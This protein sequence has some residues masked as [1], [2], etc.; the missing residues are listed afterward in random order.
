MMC[1][2]NINL[3]QLLIES[4][5]KSV[6]ETLT[7]S[8]KSAKISAI[9]TDANIKKISSNFYSA[10]NDRVNYKSAVDLVSIYNKDIGI[11][12]YE[13]YKKLCISLFTY[14]FK[15]PEYNLYSEKILSKHVCQYCY[16]QSV[17]AL[18]HYIEKAMFPEISILPDNLIPICTNCNSR[19]KDNF[20]YP[21][22]T[23][24]QNS[25]WLVCTVNSNQS[26]RFNISK[27]V[28]SNKFEEEI[29]TDLQT[30]FHTL[31]IFNKYIKK[32]QAIVT[33]KFSIINNLKKYGQNKEDVKKILEQTDIDTNKVLLS[34]TEF[35]LIAIRKA[36]IENFDNIWNAL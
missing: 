16:V 34:N 7:N 21:Y 2:S 30:Q 11:D 15:K 3:T 36:I 1:E 35:Y 28:A 12:N 17:N 24:L 14:D 29:L 33:E 9:Y 6:I 19:K 22:F 18:D 4:N 5:T 25:E 10:L 23:I 31:K 32:G 27:T 13:E 20:V 26:F 8:K